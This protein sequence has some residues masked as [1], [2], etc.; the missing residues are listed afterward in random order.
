MED[1]FIIDGHCDTLYKIYKDG[2]DL[3]DN[4]GILQNSIQNM[5][6]GGVKLQFFAAWVG[7]KT[8][9]WCPAVDVNIMVSL[10]YKHILLNNQ[11]IVAV[12]CYKDIEENLNNEKILALL[13]IEGGE[14]LSGRLEMLDIYYRLGVRCLTLTWNNRNEIGN[15]VMEDN[16]EQGLTDFG[17]KVVKQMN[18]LGMIIDVS[19]ISK[20][21]FWDVMETSSQPVI[22]SHSNSLYVHNNKRNLDDNQIKA[23]ARH[24]GIVGINFYPGFL[25]DGKASILDILKHIDHISFICGNVDCIAFGSDFDGIEQV[26]DGVENSSCFNNIVEALYKL[27]YS[28][29]DIKKIC[30]G[31]YIRYLKRVL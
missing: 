22:A 10:Y 2:D 20:R 29:A 18:N 27:N 8:H 1:N 16:S 28:E 19:H 30:H 31:N 3:Y 5:L 9:D 14:A 17:R 23:I 15:G 4:R 6:R 11:Y 25:G 26:V 13:A 12:F 21:G 7:D 24:G